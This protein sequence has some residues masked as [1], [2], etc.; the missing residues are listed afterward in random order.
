MTSSSS[1]LCKDR[2]RVEDPTRGVVLSPGHSPARAQC[3]LNAGSASWGLATRATWTTSN[4]GKSTIQQIGPN[5]PSILHIPDESFSYT[6]PHSPPP[7]I[8]IPFPSHHPLPPASWI[9]SLYSH[10]NRSAQGPGLWA[11]LPTRRNA[12]GGLGSIRLFL[13]PLSSS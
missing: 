3:P 13:Q 12:V 7:Y 6:R 11:G 9:R 5:A 10:L 4:L 1:W 8:I 2:H